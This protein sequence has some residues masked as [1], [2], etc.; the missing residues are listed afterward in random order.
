MICNND[1]KNVPDLIKPVFLNKSRHS[2]NLMWSKF[3]ILYKANESANDQD[4]I[5]TCLFQLR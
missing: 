2:L 1:C 3:P 4:H 5:T